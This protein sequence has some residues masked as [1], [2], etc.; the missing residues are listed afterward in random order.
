MNN[1]INV[2]ECLFKNWNSKKQAVVSGDREVSYNCLC[3]NVVSF[4]KRI[5]TNNDVVIIYL[6]NSIEY[7][8]SYF[9]TILAGKKAFL[10]N[11]MYPVKEVLTF[12]KQVSCDVIITNKELQLPDSIKVIYPILHE[13]ECNTIPEIND[14]KNEGAIIIPTSGTMGDA[15]LIMLTHQNL[16]TNVLDI[17]DSY[18]ELEEDDWELI[19]LPLTSIFCNTTE[20]LVPFFAGMT[21]DI[22]TGGFNMPRI[23]KEMAEKRISYCQMV[24][25]ILKMFVLFY[26]KSKYELPYFKRITIGG[27]PINQEELKNIS[28]II[29]PI[30]VLQGYGMTE[31]SPVISSQRYL[32]D[33]K[34]YGC[35]GSIMK[36]LDVKIV[37]DHN[38]KE[39]NILVKGPSVC[40]NT[41]DGKQLV[42]DEGWL[43]T[44]DIGYIDDDGEIYVCGRSKN[45]IVVGGMNVYPEE[46]ESLLKTYP[47]IVEAL[48]Y[49]DNDKLEGENVKAKIVVRE[50]VNIAKL[51]QFCHNNLPIYKIPVSVQI[52]SELQK[53]YSSKVKRNV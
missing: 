53:T 34:K 30:R 24:P 41:Y 22:W 35:S 16:M 9:S 33:N 4:S 51:L 12:T 40:R 25:A 52:V 26:T 6:E 36:S 49:G 7:V 31:A 38:D 29:R 18:S 19:I 43:N 48:V 10:I 20:L 45:I 1:N 8:V 42:D 44:G 17:I 14:A 47:G 28:E 37:S 27:E 13:E 46:V 15:K 5:D 3:A 21:I 32:L 39:G 11:P 50:Q 23:I 2:V